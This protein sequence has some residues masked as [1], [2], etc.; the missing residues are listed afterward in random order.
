VGDPEE[1]V[2][3]GGGGH[4]Q[5]E[6]CKSSWIRVRV[7]SEKERGYLKELVLKNIQKRRKRGE[8]GNVG[9]KGQG[10]KDS[11]SLKKVY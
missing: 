10:K 2:N 8:K 4:R 1:G 6:P 7:Q 11:T 5:H 3:S 9:K